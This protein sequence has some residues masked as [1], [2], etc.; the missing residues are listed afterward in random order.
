MMGFWRGVGDLGIARLGSLLV[1]LL[2]WL[3]MRLNTTMRFV[4]KRFDYEV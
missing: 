2:L 3:E 1:V 4:I